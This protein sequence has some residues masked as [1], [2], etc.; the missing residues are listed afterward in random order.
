MKKIFVIMLITILLV[1]CNKND[2]FEFTIEMVTPMVFTVN[3]SEEVTAGMK[4]P[5]NSLG[6]FCEIKID[7]DTILLDQKGQ[8][9]TTEDFNSGDKI[10]VLSKKNIKIT[11]KNRKIDAATVQMVKD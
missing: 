10:I 1:A 3:C 8:S 2:T 4:E 7:N 6:Y 9:I 5:I 11:E